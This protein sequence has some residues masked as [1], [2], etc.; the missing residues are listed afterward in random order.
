MTVAGYAY[1]GG[2]RGIQRVDVSLDGGKTW[3]VAQ[4]TPPPQVSC[5]YKLHTIQRGA[6]Q[7]TGGTYIPSFNGMVHAVSLTPK[8]AVRYKC[9]DGMMHVHTN[10]HVSFFL[11]TLQP[12]GRVWAW[13]LWRAE[14]PIPKEIAQDKKGTMKRM[15]RQ[16]LYSAS[17]VSFAMPW[18]ANVF[19]QRPPTLSLNRSVFLENHV[20]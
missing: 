1:S 14:V 17:C 7:H 4:L 19:I 6:M 16:C 10:G 11:C 2:G 13:T 20:V 3:T 9:V 12:Y 8:C 18:P 15:L 5:N